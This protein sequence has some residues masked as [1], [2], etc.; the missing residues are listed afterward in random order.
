MENVM[1]LEKKKGFTLIE[2]M[3]VLAIIAILAVVLIP[4]SQIFK[5]NSK[6]AGVTTNVNTVRGYLETTVTNNGGAYGYLGYDQLISKMK[7]DFNLSASNNT[8]AGDLS[9][10]SSTTNADEQLIN[11]FAKGNAS[12]V[13]ISKTGSINSSISADTDTSHDGAVII[14]VY[15]DG[16]AVFGYDKGGAATSIFKV[17]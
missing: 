7:S 15:G 6:N 11:P 16:Y 14:Y 5:N 8:N 3:I 4:K 10:N 9:P 12:V 17:K 2:L 1:T 13:I